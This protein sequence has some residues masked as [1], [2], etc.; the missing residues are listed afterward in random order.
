M[1]A[2]I[3]NKSITEAIPKAK[4]GTNKAITEDLQ[5]EKVGTNIVIH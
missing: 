4:V 3:T 2:R 5:E 1:W